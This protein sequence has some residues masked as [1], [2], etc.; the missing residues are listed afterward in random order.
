MAA[1][2]IDMQA[3]KSPLTRDQFLEKTAEATHL[4]VADVVSKFV[5]QSMEASEWGGAITAIKTW[6]KT[7]TEA[8]ENFKL[9]ELGTTVSKNDY[10]QFASEKLG[11]SEV[12]MT[13]MVWDTYNPNAIWYVI[14][15]IGILAIIA[16]ILYDNIV[17]KPKERAEKFSR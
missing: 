4:S 7:M 13:Q 1:R 15:G 9:G 10:F 17:I 5:P 6:G 11:M 14:V 16:L 12:E 2:S 8:D 3:L